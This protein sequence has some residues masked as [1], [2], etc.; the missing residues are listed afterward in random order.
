MTDVENLAKRID[1]LQDTIQA[2]QASTRSAPSAISSDDLDHIDG[3]FKSQSSTIVE[4]SAE[5]RRLKAAYDTLAKRWSERGLSEFVAK[6]VEPIVD[7]LIAQKREAEAGDQAVRAETAQ[8]ASNAQA[9]A[10]KSRLFMEA[11]ATTAAAT[12]RSYIGEVS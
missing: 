9:T 5:V 11:S 10:A 4:L 7:Q 1:S 2:L 6:A 12:I 8:L 3:R